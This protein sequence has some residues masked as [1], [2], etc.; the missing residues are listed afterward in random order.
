MERQIWSENKNLFLKGAL[1]ICPLAE[2]I[3][4]LCDWLAKLSD[5][6]TI[7][8][9]FS[10]LKK[11]QNYIGQQSCSPLRSELIGLFW[12]VPASSSFQ[13]IMPDRKKETWRRFFD[14]GRNDRKGSTAVTCQFG[15][16]PISRKESFCFLLTS[17]S[18]SVSEFVWR[19][20]EMAWL[21]LHSWWLKQ[22]RS[23]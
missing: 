2:R 14:S 13:L 19:W 10:A 18:T 3:S 11:E 1:E 21:A 9:F 12:S 23:K 4:V 20:W 5:R 17:T 22:E 15:S 8:G 7:S 6:E 16:G